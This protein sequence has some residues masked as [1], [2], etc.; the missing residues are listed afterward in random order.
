MTLLMRT[1]LVMSADTDMVTNTG[2]TMR[3]QG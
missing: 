2:I 1:K 3:F